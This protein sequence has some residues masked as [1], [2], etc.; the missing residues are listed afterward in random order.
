MVSTLVMMMFAWATWQINRRQH[1]YQYVPSTAIFTG[2]GRA[3]IS[4]DTVFWCLIVNNSDVPIVI[5]DVREEISH[6]G[7]A[8]VN[9]GFAFPEKGSQGLYINQFPWVILGKRFAIWSRVIF[10][11]Q[12]ATNRTWDTAGGTSAFRVK[13]AIDTYDK[14]RGLE[15]ELVEVQV[16]NLPEQEPSLSRSSAG[17]S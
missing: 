12:G 2:H 16:T 9:L 17:M 5:K 13:L 15:T 10:V 3:P 1:Q 7:D 6:S 8:E 11:Y 14:I 4:G